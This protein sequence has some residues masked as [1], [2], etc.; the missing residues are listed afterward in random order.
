M[1]C[2][3]P[4]FARCPVGRGPA[5]DPQPSRWELIDIFCQKHSHVLRVRYP[6]ATNYGGVKILVYNF[7]IATRPY[8]WEDR[9]LDPHF[10]S[11]HPGPVARFEPNDIGWKRAMRLARDISNGTEEL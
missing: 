8:D 10:Q 2:W 5:P 3:I 1:G 11:C 4:G 9:A 7:S 6:D